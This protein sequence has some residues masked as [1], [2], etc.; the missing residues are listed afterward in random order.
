MTQ[1]KR[2]SLMTSV[3][4]AVVLL[5]CGVAVA[6][7][8]SSQATAQPT[9]SIDQDIAMLRKDL[10][11]QRKKLIAANMSLTADEAEKFWPIYDQYVSELVQT[12]NTKYELIKQY[13]QNSGT[14]TADQADS[15]VKRWLNVDESVT[16]LRQKYLPIF[17]KVLSAQKTALY[18]Q[19]DRRVQLMID[20]QL[21]SQLPLIEP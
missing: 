18:Y 7:D 9:A 11:S 12:N 5:I 1:G 17:R 14:L 13:V 19:L 6:Q 2:N 3:T 8:N 21:A 4:V 10:R 20:L 16:Q 15:A